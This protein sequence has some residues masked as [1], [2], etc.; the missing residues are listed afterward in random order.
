[1]KLSVAN[2]KPPTPSLVEPGNV[3]P[4]E[5]GGVAF[6]LV[7]AIAGNDACCVGFSKD[8]RLQ[9]VS[10]VDTVVLTPR[11]VLGFVDLGVVLTP[12]T[13]GVSPPTEA[14]TRY[15]V[16]NL[17]ELRILAHHGYISNLVQ[18][19]LSQSQVTA[20]QHLVCKR[21]IKSTGDQDGYVVTERGEAH[22]DAIQH[23]ALPEA[24]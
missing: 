21:L 6:W 9:T 5:G 19:P 3:Y 11:P 8:G 17:V 16:L 10:H 14:P 1:M 12:T 15:L 22:L 20:Y 18:I 24:P 23:L 4:A 13:V 7:V 2:L